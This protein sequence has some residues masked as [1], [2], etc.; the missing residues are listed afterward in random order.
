MIG[1]KIER[2]DYQKLEIRFLRWGLEAG[3]IRDSIVNLYKSE[4]SP[5]WN[6]IVPHAQYVLGFTIEEQKMSVISVKGDGPE[7]YEK[8]TKIKYF[9]LGVPISGSQKFI[10][11]YNSQLQSFTP[12]DEEN[13][14][15]IVPYIYQLDTTLVSPQL[16]WRSIIKY[17]SV[18]TSIEYRYNEFVYSEIVPEDTVTVIVKDTVIYNVV[19]VDIVIYNII[20]RDSIDYTLVPDTVYIP[21]VTDI[22]G[23]EHVVTANARV[24]KESGGILM[25]G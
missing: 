3:E 13:L 18:F 7:P 2:K 19:H 8:G 9:T 22:S 25:R 4:I 10:D 11:M 14:S 16:R 6:D 12:P 21:V 23:A 17:D 24:S 5:Y 1:Q 15:D 20:E